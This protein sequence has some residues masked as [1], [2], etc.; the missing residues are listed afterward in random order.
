MTNECRHEATKARRHEGANTLRLI[1]VLV[2]SLLVACIAGCAANQEQAQQTR[3]PVYQE[4]PTSQESTQQAAT[5]GPSAVWIA[6]TNPHGRAQW[7]RHGYRDITD[8]GETEDYPPDFLN[9]VAGD[10]DVLKIYLEARLPA[11]MDYSVH[12]NTVTQTVTG[13]MSGTQSNSPSA[14]PTASPS[15]TGTTTGG[16][17][18]QAQTPTAST[19]IDV[20]VAAG[21]GSSATGGQPAAN[22]AG[23]AGAAT[24]GTQTNTPTSTGNNTNN[25]AASSVPALDSNQRD[26]LLQLVRDDGALRSRIGAAII[27]GGAQPGDS[28]VAAILSLMARDAQLDRAVRELINQPATTPSPATEGGD[29]TND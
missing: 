11:R 19:A 8:E 21:P 9:A 15:T 3:Q 23:P 25:A 22:A 7:G 4:Q 29:G 12:G 13:E 1:A 16:A 10:P 26:L 6:A 24:G 17:S 20:P 28:Q 27:G 18:D 14:T 5:D 2:V